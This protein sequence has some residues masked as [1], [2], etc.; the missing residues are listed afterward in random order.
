MGLLKLFA[1]TL[2]LDYF[3]GNAVGFGFIDI[4]LMLF[5]IY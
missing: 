3:T 1:G 4:Y 2:P 5:N